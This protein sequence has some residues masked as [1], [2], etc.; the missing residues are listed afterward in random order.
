MADDPIVTDPIGDMTGLATDA[1]VAGTAAED[2]G[3]PTSGQEIYD[4]I[5]A[6]IQPELTS[7][8]YPTLAEKYKDETE[9]DRAA[10]MKRYE[11]AFAEYDKRYAVFLQKVNTDVHEMKKSARDAAE[12]KAHEQDVQSEADLLAQME[13]A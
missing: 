11:E 6:E 8:I 2:G 7:A 1:P 9:D 5:M 3:G 10:R 12:A 13:S 4:A